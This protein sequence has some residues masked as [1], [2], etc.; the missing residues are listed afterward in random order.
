MAWAWEE[1]S[2]EVPRAQKALTKALE[3][4]SRDELLTRL[5]PEDRSWV[6]SC[7]GQGAGA[8]L[9]AAP[10]T[11]VEKFTDGDFCAA[12]RLRLGQGVFPSG[13]SCP[14]T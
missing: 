3:K 14:K 1:D 13:A 11:E 12:V 5:S 4:Q 7:G 2:A 6:R 9:S 10:A 8:W